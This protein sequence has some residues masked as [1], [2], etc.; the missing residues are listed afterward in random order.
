VTGES[1]TKFAAFGGSASIIGN[2]S[3]YA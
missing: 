2:A 1:G 3:G